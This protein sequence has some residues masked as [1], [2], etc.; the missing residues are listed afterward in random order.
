MNSF[1]FDTEYL[2]TGQSLPFTGNWVNTVLSR[3]SL[4]VAYVSG[5]TATVNLQAPS[6]LGSYGSIFAAGG[7]AE[8]YTFSSTAGVTGYM[9]PAYSDSPISSIRIVAT[10]AGAGRIWAYVNYQN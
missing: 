10:G 8:A 5:T 4:I 6:L 7:T 1:L 3:N 9:T 2:A